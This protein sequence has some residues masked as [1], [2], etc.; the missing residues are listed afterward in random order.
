MPNEIAIQ[1]E[2]EPIVKLLCLNVRCKHN[3]GMSNDFTCNLKR[4]TIDENGA[5]ACFEMSENART[6]A[7]ADS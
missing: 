4:I 1:F 6:Q 2:F 5:C 7:E 3:Q